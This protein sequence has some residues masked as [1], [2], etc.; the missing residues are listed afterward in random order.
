MTELVNVKLEFIDDD[1]I[2]ILTMDNQKELNALSSPTLNSIDKALD[3]V[4]DNKKCLGLI[5]TGEGRAFVAGANIK[6]MENY[7]WEEGRN[8][9]DKAQTIFNRIENLPIPVI[10]AVNGFALG[11]GCELSMSCDIRLASEKAIFGQPEVNLGLIPCFGGTQ[12]LQRLVGQ[13]IAKELIYTAR[14]VKAQEAK[15]IGLVNEVYPAE[16]LV[17]KAIEMMRLI[18]TKSPLAVSLSKSA[19]NEGG[20]LDII[21]GLEIEKNLAALSFS[22]EEKEIG[23]KAFIRKETPKFI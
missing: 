2:A 4:E 5:I 7:G 11:G 6:E 23:V 14:N 8:Y 9:A 15:A 1:R 20:N 10:A 13:G 22:S 21:R 17:D 3:A 19:I 18:N 12:R 16:E